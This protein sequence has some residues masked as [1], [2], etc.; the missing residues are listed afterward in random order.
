MA[1]RRHDRD[2]APTAPQLLQLL[3]LLMMR[4]NHRV[5]PESIAHEIWPD[6]TPPGGVRAGVHSLV[7]ELRGCLEAAGPTPSGRSA[8]A[9]RRPGYVLRLGPDQLDVLVFDQ[10]VRQGQEAFLAGQYEQASRL[11]RTGLG[12][13]SGDPMANVRHGPVLSAYAAELEEHRRAARFLRIE[14]EIEAG[15]AEELLGELRALV[16]ADPLDEGSHAQLMRVLGRL[17]RRSEALAL[18]RGLRERL[19]DEL[20]LEPSETVQTLRRDVLR[21]GLSVR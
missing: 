14:A 9:V 16:A 19:V 10:L 18:Y 15:R 2:H 12:L 7:S 21:A 5:H 6:E 11:L 20:G 8:L 3:A 17:G 4:C 1:V 13:W